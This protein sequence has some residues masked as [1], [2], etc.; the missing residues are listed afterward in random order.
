MTVTADT[1]AP[2]ATTATI[3]DIMDRYRNRGLQ[4]PFTKD[5]LGRASVP[6]SLIPRT[7]QA[8][9]VLD[10]I[11]EDG[12]PTDT[13]EGIRKAPSTEYQQRLGEWL[14]GTYADVF[15]FVDPSSDDETAIR[16]AFRSYTPVGQQHRMVSLFI[17]LC[18]EAGIREK[19]EKESKPRTR[20][21]SVKGQM[22]VKRKK[23]KQPPALPFAGK[24]PSA[25]AGLID[26]L[27]SVKDGWTQQQH[28][29]FMRTFGAVLD[30]CYP[31]VEENDTAQDVNNNDEQDDPN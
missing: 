31:I 28:D 25:I 7:L 4:K 13:F 1:S 2:Y 9:I 22:S 16:D 20:T 26:S 6:D 17:G 24:V 3:V 14:K 18:E 15:S 30:F 11:D 29:K 12:N 21:P 8:L 19:S 5:V 23:A 27:P 10:L